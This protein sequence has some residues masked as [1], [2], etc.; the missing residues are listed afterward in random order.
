MIRIRFRSRVFLI[1]MVVVVVVVVVVVETEFV[2]RLATMS[3]KDYLA[4]A[5]LTQQS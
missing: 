4:C 5:N 3:L 2:G 1:V